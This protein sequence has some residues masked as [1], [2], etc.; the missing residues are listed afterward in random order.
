MNVGMGNAYKNSLDAYCNSINNRQTKQINALRY[1][2]GMEGDKKRDSVFISDTAKTFSKDYV[3]AL[4]DSCA[5]T[6]ESQL[7]FYLNHYNNPQAILDAINFGK[8]V[9]CGYNPDFKDFGVVNFEYNGSKQVVPV[10]AV[11]KMSTGSLQE[12]KAVDNVLKLENESYYSYT[13][14]NGNTYPWSVSDGRVGWVRTESLLSAPDGK[15]QVSGACRKEMSLAKGILSELAKGQSL[16]IYDKENV[17]KVCK[18]VG[19]QPGYFTVDAGAGKHNYYLEETGKVINLDKQMER[20]N[21]KN[22]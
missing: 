8:G 9:S 1:M 14:S 18:K 21:N 17:L 22:Y 13:T 16:F 10:Y 6:S 2:L 20:V 11:P 19:I 4:V 7:T 5:N 15:S 3:V 12:I